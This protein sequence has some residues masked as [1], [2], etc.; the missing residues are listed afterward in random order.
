MTATIH[1]DAPLVAAVR[2]AL[3]WPLR[4]KTLF[5]MIRH[6]G[7]D[8]IVLVFD[9]DCEIAVKFGPEIDGK[10][11]LDWTVVDAKGPDAIQAA[12][13]GHAL[14]VFFIKVGLIEPDVKAT[15]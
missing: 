6:E 13:I 1:A 15:H 9:A 12:R 2:D 10:F 8:E 3:G 11:P 5:T 4:D 7:A 14:E